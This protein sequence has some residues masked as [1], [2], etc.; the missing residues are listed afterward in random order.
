MVLQRCTG[1]NRIKYTGQYGLD[2][3][4]VAEKVYF[5]GPVAEVEGKQDF[6]QLNEDFFPQVRG[7][8]PINAFEQGNNVCLEGIFKIATP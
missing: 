2:R 6:I 5:K 8:E 3:T 1:W 7:Y 4:L